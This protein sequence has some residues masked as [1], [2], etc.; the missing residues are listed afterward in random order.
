MN[1]KTRESQQKYDMAT[2]LTYR[3]LEMI[4]QRRLAKYN[5]FVSNMKYE[6]IHPHRQRNALMVG[7]SGKDRMEWLRVEVYRIR[8]E[9]FKGHI[10]EYLPNPVSLLDGFIILAALS[11]PIFENNP[12]NRIT[13]LKQMRSKVYLRNNSI[14]AHG[15]GPVPKGDYARFRDFIGKIFERFCSVEK[16]DIEKMD[17]VFR[18][19]PI[20]DTKED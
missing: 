19:I 17:K 20:S 2:L 3:L 9:L 11:D 14:F 8:Q 18:W 4:E 13:V 7:M 15:L 10:S 6:E 5:L 16:V 12:K 1:A